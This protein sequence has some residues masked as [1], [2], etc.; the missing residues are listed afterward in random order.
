MQTAL[1][2]VLLDVWSQVLVHDSNVVKLGSEQFPVFSGKKK[3]L[4]QVEFHFDGKTI[5]GIEQN[6]NTKSNWAKMARSG[7]KVIQFAQDGRYMAV[8][9]VGKVTL[10]AESAD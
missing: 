6:P 7:V 5:I 3:H 10:Y 2:D 4:H 9:A 1:T 8:V